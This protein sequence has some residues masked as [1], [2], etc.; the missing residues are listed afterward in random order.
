[1]GIKSHWMNVSRPAD[2]IELFGCDG[3]YGGLAPI[4]DRKWNVA[5]SVSASRV[6]EHRGD[7][8][9]LFTS[10]MRENDGLRSD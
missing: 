7:I 6:R 9:A 3:C 1:M 10:L 8:N 4:E 2:A 5:F